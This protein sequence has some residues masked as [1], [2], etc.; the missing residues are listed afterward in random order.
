M[1]SGPYYILAFYSTL[2]VGASLL[3]GWL[4]SLIRM[5][6]TRTQLAM[7]FVAGLMLG[8]ALFHLLP[9][10]IA[11][12]G[13]AHAVEIALWW[14]MAGLVLMLLLLRS[15]HFH[16]H[17]FSS[18]EEAH[19]DHD[20]G[21]G[22]H[23]EPAANNTVRS[24]SW[25]GMAIGLGLH[26]LI[27][28][29]ALGAS[30]KAEALAEPGTTLVGLG[31]L[32]AILLHKPLDAMSIT[33]LMKAD[34]W[35]KGAQTRANLMF[36]LLCPLGALLFF[37]GVAQLGDTRELVIG[38]ALAFSAGVFLCIALSDLLPEVH[39]HSHDKGK[40]TL[41]FLLGIGLAFALG[42]LEPDA[43]HALEILP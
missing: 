24:I 27:D 15:F 26:T 16:Q 31:V 35:S 10:G 30:I 3:G 14:V 13:G 33:T 9:H 40:L 38:S 8:V 20:H 28:G 22:H 37:W 18:D 6:H 11:E 19:H 7:S 39:F 5:T 1:S 43:V 36:S 23:H 12:I 29:I 17:D 32:L 21:S 4:P 42:G 41:A 2:I 25:L 34:G